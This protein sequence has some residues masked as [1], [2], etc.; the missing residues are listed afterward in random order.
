MARP[1][2]DELFWE[3][4]SI[5]YPIVDADAHVNEPPELWQDRVPQRFRK[6]AP[7]VERTAEGDA[8]VFDDGKAS[9]HVGL[10]AMAGR[11]FLDYTNKNVS[12][13]EMRPGSWDT[14]ARLR[15]LEADGIWGQVLYPSITLTGAKIYGDE[16]ELQHA[17]VR[18]YNEWLLDMCG[19]SAG[20]L[21]PQAIIPACGVERAVE[22]LEWAI[23]HDHRGAIISAFPNGTLSHDPADDAFFG[24]AQEADIPVAVHIGSFTSRNTNRPSGEWNTLQFIGQAIGPRCGSGTIEATLSLIFSGIFEKFPRLKLL[25]V[26]A[27]IGWIPCLLEQSDDF[28]LRYRWFTHAVEQMPTMPSKIFHRNFWISFMQD[29]AGLE[30][31][32]HMNL[33]HLMFSTDYPHTATD[34]PNTRTTITRLFRGLPKHEV[35]KLLRDNAV[36]LYNLKDVP[37]TLA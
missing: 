33:D 22:E 26:E 9:M 21:I 4:A 32:H 24:L 8:W 35:R 1:G 7:R 12:Y 31:R 20:R 6:R 29:A 34:W 18:A 5:D 27:N 3:T 37:E 11:S 2:S 16:P 17:C 28:F 30:M 10:T 15:D 36:A 25:L 14:Q 23:S 13:A 19:D